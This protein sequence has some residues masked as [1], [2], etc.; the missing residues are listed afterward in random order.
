[1]NKIYRLIWNAT[2]RLW[3]VAGELGRQG[4]KRTGGR[5]LVAAC[6]LYLLPLAALGGELPSGGTVVTGV[7]AIDQFDK[8]LSFTQGSELLAIEWQQSNIRDG[9]RAS[10]N[11]PCAMP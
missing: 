8:H 10:V 11:E 6:S 7:G 1:M 4:R 5:G 9:H 2:A 3:Q